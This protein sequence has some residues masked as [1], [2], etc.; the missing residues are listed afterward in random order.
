MLALDQRGHGETEWASDYAWQRW[1]ED[2]EGFAEALGLATFDLVGH[3]IRGAVASRFAGMHPDRVEH[4][5]LLDAFYADIVFSPEWK[6]FWSL[7]ARLYPDDGFASHEEYVNTV[8]T[9]FPRG[10]RDVVEASATTLIRDDSG[11]LRR[12]PTTDPSNTWES[13]PTEDEENALRRKVSYPTLVAQAEHSEMH[14]ADHNQRVAA[15]YPRGE[16]AAILR[17]LA[18]TS[19]TKTPHSPSISSG[20]SSLVSDCPDQPEFSAGIADDVV[21]IPTK[22][23]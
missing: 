16:A 10:D 4:L 2:I 1:V 23:P 20:I 18:T 9:V 6:H 3:S 19:R 8:L 7:V 5:I 14:V 21:H 11:R 22:R 12:P 15:I 17:G 13:Q